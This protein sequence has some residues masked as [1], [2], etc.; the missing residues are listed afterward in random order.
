MRVEDEAGGRAR[1]A[2]ADVLV[3][4]DREGKVPLSLPAASLIEFT[5]NIAAMP[6][7][8]FKQV[9]VAGAISCIKGPFAHCA[10]D[11]LD[12]AC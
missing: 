3:L 2:T 10:C 6:V 11:D 9:F 8:S 12:F 7:T 1:S 5:Y 4:T